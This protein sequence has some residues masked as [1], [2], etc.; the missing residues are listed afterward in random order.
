MHELNGNGELI[1]GYCAQ[2]DF[3][4]VCGQLIAKW[5][6]DGIEVKCERCKELL[7]IPFNQI[8]GWNRVYSVKTEI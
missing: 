1:Q 5:H 7:V 4:C 3:R 8:E 6:Q 2:H